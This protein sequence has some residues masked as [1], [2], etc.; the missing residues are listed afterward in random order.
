LCWS[1]TPRLEPV[2]LV[3]YKNPKVLGVIVLVLTV[4]CNICFW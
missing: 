1:T 2:P 3:W 4:I